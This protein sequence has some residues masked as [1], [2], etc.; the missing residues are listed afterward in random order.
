[1]FEDGNNNV[2]IGVSETEIPFAE[3][4]GGIRG[5]FNE[6]VLGGVLEFVRRSTEHTIGHGMEDP[7]LIMLFEEEGGMNV[8][9]AMSIDMAIKTVEAMEKTGF[10]GRHKLAVYTSEAW[11]VA[12]EGPE[13]LVRVANQ[14][15][16]AGSLRHV[17]GAYE[18]L[19]AVIADLTTKREWATHAKIEKSGEIRT[20]LEWSEIIETSPGT[21]KFSFVHSL[22]E[23]LGSEDQRRIWKAAADA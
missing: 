16:E 14:I 8:A 3:W 5:E 15:A 6:E 19:T 22:E 20:L 4:M 17:D 1:M 18:C 23:R 9:P 12:P 2:G 10:L 7:P 13:D 11:S 21:S